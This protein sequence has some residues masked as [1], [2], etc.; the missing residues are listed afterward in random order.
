M[1]P[2]TRLEEQ[3]QTRRCLRLRRRLSECLSELLEQYLA[4][5]TKLRHH[6]DTSSL[7]KYYDIYDFSPEELE[8]AESSLVDFS[9]AEEMSLRSLSLLYHR[10]YAVRKSMLCCLLAFPVDGTQ[11]DATRWGLAVEEMQR[12]ATASGDWIQRLTVILH[13]QDREYDASKVFDGVTKCVR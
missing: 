4:A 9:P 3:S 2:V 12:I 5:K 11:V 7:A 8:E 1:P 6:T 13:E 10:L